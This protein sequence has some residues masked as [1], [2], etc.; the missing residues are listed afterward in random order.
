M[1]PA[2]IKEGMNLLVVSAQGLKGK[3]A[4]LLSDLEKLTGLMPTANSL[5]S[6]NSYY[7]AL[8]IHGR[9]HGR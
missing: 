8:A 6:N 5:D 3:H 9:Y 1:L 7:R 4:T 2:V